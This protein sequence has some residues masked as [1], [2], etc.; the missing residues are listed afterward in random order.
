MFYISNLTKTTPP[1][2]F[3]HYKKI[4]QLVLGKNFELSVSFISPQ[5]SREL[6]KK[7]RNK[8]KTANV[9]SFPL[10]KNSGEI[11]IN[12]KTKKEAQKFK[13]SHKK[14]IDFLLIHGCLHLLGLDHG[15]KMDLLEQKFLSKAG[16]K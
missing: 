3:L 8:N 11:L 4:S 13:M 12:L 6:N 5:K 1:S 10:E 2:D 7:F 16:Y 9:L 14:Y 15:E